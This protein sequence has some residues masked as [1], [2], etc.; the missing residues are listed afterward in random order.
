MGGERER[1]RGRERERERERKQLYFLSNSIKLLN[2]ENAWNYLKIFK[3]EEYLKKN[4][5]FLAFQIRISF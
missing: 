5:C 4:Y 2:I 1:K 3:Y